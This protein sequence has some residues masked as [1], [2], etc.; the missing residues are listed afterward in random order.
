MNGSRNDTTV[1]IRKGTIGAGTVGTGLGGGVR[2][3]GSCPPEWEAGPLGGLADEEG[4]ATA[5]YAI[6]TMA[7]VEQMRQTAPMTKAALYLRQSSDR[8]KTELGIDRQRERCSALAEAKGWEVVAEYVDNDTSATKPRGA[9]TAWHTLIQ[10][11]A[12]GSVEV[13]VA[14]DVDRLLRTLRDLVTLTESG[15]KVVTVDGEIDLASADGEFRAT[16]AA[17]LAR[18]EGKRKAE[19]QRR[20]NQQRRDQGIPTSGR[21]PYGYQWIDQAGRRE[22]GTAAAYD[23]VPEQ[24]EVIRASYASLLAGLPV[25]R[26]CKELND[27]GRTTK[28]GAVWRPTTLRRMLLSPFYCA[29]LP[30]PRT[31]GKAY[32]Q[33]D[34]RRDDCVPG[35]WPAIVEV[36]TWLAAKDRLQDPARKTSPGPT[37]R[38][39]LSGLAL[40]GVCMEP[41]RAGG[42]DA[43]I[44]S[45]RCRSMAHFMR[46]GIPL[47]DFIE[48]VVVARLSAPDASELLMD[49]DA[50]NLDGLRSERLALQARMES[51]AGLIADGLMTT[52]EARAGLKRGRERIAEIDGQMSDAGRVDT[53]S[54]VVGQPDVQAAWDALSLGRKRA[55]LETLM[56][57]VVHSVGQGFRGMLSDEAMAKTVEIRWHE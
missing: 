21:V 3:V 22:R 12:Q 48:R 32:R 57:V 54:D 28:D 37:R 30:K 11:A 1:A 13:V 51:I 18:F 36:E 55:I 56:T 20:A 46:R 38:W 52:D 29:L 42:G 4:S 15:L 6:A 49:R 31:D 43:G 19:R 23:V 34:I 35:A 17:G 7:A 2:R 10:D 9:G 44:H 39:L 53:L 26:I 5:E 33:E 24:A 16:I 41:I 8:D 27:A 47:D 25:G 50:V 45:Y 14:V 40:C